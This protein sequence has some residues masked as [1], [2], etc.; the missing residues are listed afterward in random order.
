M[1][2]TFSHLPGG[3]DFKWK[4]PQAVDFIRKSITQAKKEKNRTKM[5][6]W[7]QARVDFE[8]IPLYQF[9]QL[10]NSTERLNAGRTIYSTQQQCPVSKAI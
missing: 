3:V 1:G 4:C 8:Q 2:F 6:H 5:W 9:P 10:K 7:L